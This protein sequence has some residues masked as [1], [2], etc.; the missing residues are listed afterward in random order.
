M[1]SP[2]QGHYELLPEIGQNG[3]TSWDGKRRGT[4]G[5]QS[6]KMASRSTMVDCCLEARQEPVPARRKGLKQ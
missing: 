5:I 1:R 6:C 4:D 2:R 3:S